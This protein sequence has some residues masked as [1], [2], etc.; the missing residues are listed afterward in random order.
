[1]NESTESFMK[2]TSVTLPEMKTSY[3]V[4]HPVKSK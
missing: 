2:C 1:M 3:H 4:G